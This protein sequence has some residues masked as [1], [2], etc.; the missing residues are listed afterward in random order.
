MQRRI[1][2]L[3]EATPE[4]TGARILQGLIQLLIVLNV[5]AVGTETVEPLGSTVSRVCLPCPCARM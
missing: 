5:I 1:Y 2:E 3:L 4:S